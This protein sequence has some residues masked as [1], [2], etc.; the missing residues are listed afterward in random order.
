MTNLTL[1]H[2]VET[3]LKF[4][5]VV[6]PRVVRSLSDSDVHYITR[7]RLLR[8]YHIDHP[9]IQSQVWTEDQFVSA[10]KQAVFNNNSTFY[11]GYTGS[12]RIYGKPIL[13]LRPRVDGDYSWET[14]L[15]EHTL[16]AL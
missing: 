16:E 11:R 13:F 12:A 14:L 10:C 7:D 15:L 5:Y 2:E 4:W 8:L 3:K 9:V 6:C 1:D